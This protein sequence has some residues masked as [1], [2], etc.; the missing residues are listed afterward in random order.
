M[1]V[2]ELSQWGFLTFHWK[3]FSVDST[4]CGTYFRG[5]VPVCLAK[6]E[7]SSRMILRYRRAVLDT[8]MLLTHSLFTPWSFVLK[9]LV[10]TS[11]DARYKTSQVVKLPNYRFRISDARLIVPHHS[12][13]LAYR[14]CFEYI[15]S[16]MGCMYRPCATGNPRTRLRKVCNRV[17]F[18]LLLPIHGASSLSPFHLLSSSSVRR[19]VLI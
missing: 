9:N 7:H 16:K 19:T 3:T 8:V 10:K 15:V 13:A 2:F 17:F 12:L 14:L 6:S 11:Q 18:E 1:E 4:L 5:I